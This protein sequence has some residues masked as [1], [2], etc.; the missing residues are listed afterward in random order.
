MEVPQLLLEHENAASSSESENCWSVA[1]AAG[2]R[3]PRDANMSAFPQALS[4]MHPPISLK[5][6]LC[7]HACTAA[8]PCATVVGECVGADDVGA[9]EFSGLWRKHEVIVLICE[10]TNFEALARAMNEGTRARGGVI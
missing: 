7:T 4:A 1:V 10:P 3:P 5:H 9:V 2:V 6:E 8:A